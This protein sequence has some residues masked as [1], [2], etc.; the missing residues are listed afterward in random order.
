MQ[1]DFY[2]QEVAK[3]PHNGN[4]EQVSLISIKQRVGITAATQRDPLKTGVT[5]NPNALGLRRSFL[6]NVQMVAKKR[7][8]PLK[9][10]DILYSSYYLKL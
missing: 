8:S 7:P 5:L 10:W 6:P 1:L 2:Y 3:T 4:D 9:S